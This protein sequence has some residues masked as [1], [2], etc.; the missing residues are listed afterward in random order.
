[1]QATYPLFRGHFDT[2]L[3]FVIYEVGYLS[4]FVVIE[5]VFRGYLLFGLY[6]L[7]DRDAPP[8]VVG[9]PGPYVF[10]Y[11]AILIS[12]LSYTAWH[13]GKPLKETWGTIAWGL[14]TGPVALESRSVLPLIVVHWL[15]NVV[16]DLAIW[17]GFSL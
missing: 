14:A 5:F 2:T 8:G 13:L 11:Y 16:L 4:F 7:R 3:D 12:M 6:Q 10:G 9:L 15:L 17:Q 1:M